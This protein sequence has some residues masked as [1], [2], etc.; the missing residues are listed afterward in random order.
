MRYIALF[1]GIT[2]ARVKDCFENNDMIVFIVDTGQL[3]KAI[4]QKGNNIRH[5]R[6][7]LKKNLKLIEYSPKI[8]EFIRNIFY[9]FPIKNVTIKEKNDNK[10]QVAY[11]EVDVRDKGK[12]I[13]VNSKNLKL[14]REIINRYSQIDIFIT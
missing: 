12:I 3:K 2:N 13:G 10:S 4:G 7:I 11:V 9:E 6:K 1:E 5:L 14:A 8:E